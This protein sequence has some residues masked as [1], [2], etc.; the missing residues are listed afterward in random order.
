MPDDLTL[1]AEP[2]RLRILRLVWDQERSAGEIA[3]EFT[4]TFGAVSQHLARLHDAGLLTRR[5]EWKRVFYRADREKLAPLAPL[6]E[7]LWARQLGV[8]AGLAEAEE[9]S[10]AR[11]S[12]RQPK[13]ST[14]H[15]RARRHR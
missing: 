12:T 5:R 4:S 9:R 8:L 13:R 2:T 10:A 15:A 14:R 11:R 1:L 6:L 7:Q 3:G